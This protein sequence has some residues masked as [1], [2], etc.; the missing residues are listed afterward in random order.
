MDRHTTAASLGWAAALG[1]GLGGLFDGIVLHQVLQWHHL[2]SHMPSLDRPALVTWDGLFHGVM[3][4]VAAVALWGLWRQARRGGLPQG[5]RVLG[6]ILV[7][8]GAWHVADAVLAHW[9]LG[10]HRI[11]VEAENPLAWDLGWLGA[12]GVIPLV[13][14]LGLARRG[15][16]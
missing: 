10:L 15:R 5:R 13:V 2:L 14:G 12:F 1:F 8:F 4:G 3:Y 11:R 16:A 6:A 9:L 7:G